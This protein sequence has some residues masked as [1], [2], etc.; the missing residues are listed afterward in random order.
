MVVHPRLPKVPA[1]HEF[2]GLREFRGGVRLGVLLY[3]FV[4]GVAKLQECLCLFVKALTIVAVKHCFA[5]D[6]VY[7]LWAEVIFVI[8]TVDGGENFVRRQPWILNMSQLVA[9]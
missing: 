3:H 5:Q 4:A 6:S 1:S 2:S 7:G 9:T 8:E